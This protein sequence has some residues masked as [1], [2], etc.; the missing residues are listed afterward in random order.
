MV[1]CPAAHALQVE[2][3]SSRAVGKCLAAAAGKWL[4]DAR[5]PSAGVVDV[6]PLLLPNVAHGTQLD[7]LMRFWI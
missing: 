7:Q 1:T 6:D 3:P 5:Q 4:A 2:V